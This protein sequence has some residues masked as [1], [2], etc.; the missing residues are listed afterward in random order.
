[1]RL[2]NTTSNQDRILTNAEDAK[3]LE[4]ADIRAVLDVCEDLDAR[5]SKLL[6]EIEKLEKES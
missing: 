5:I 4:S 2:N 1:M 6:A 3:D